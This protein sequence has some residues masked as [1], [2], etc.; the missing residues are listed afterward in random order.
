MKRRTTKG[1]LA[2]PANTSPNLTEEDIRAAFFEH[3]NGLF[4]WI[5][6]NTRWDDWECDILTV[7]AGGIT[8]E[9]EIKIS[10]TDFHNDSSKSRSVISGNSIALQKKF[11]AW[12]NGS[13]PNYFCYLVPEGL[14]LPDE[15]PRVAGLWYYAS[16]RGFTEVK[17]P[18]TLHQRA[19]DP[20]RLS[21]WFRSVYQRFWSY[22]MRSDVSDA[23]IDALRSERDKIKRRLHAEK[24][25]REEHH[26]LT[27]GHLRS[28]LKSILNDTNATAEEK[29]L[30]ILVATKEIEW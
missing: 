10:R 16:E 7:D 29:L 4:P 30:R 20:V 28:T 24:K 17:P 27:D 1:Q 22:K 2:L 18:P 23:Q 21:T 8:S 11:D 13:G 9:W 25:F 19:L 5:F 15:L 26:Y 14:L 6:P 12:E 3:S